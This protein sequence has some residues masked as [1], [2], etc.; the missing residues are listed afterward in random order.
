M[1]SYF[2][3]CSCDFYFLIW[4]AK[5][6]QGLQMIVRFDFICF[7]SCLCQVQVFAMIRRKVGSVK[8]HVHRLQKL[9]VDM[10]CVITGFT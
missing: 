9:L 1:E 5:N 7:S 2:I 8:V 4:H 6:T 3:Y 10:A